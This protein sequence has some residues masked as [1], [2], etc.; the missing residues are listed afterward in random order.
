[1][2]YEPAQ[3][4]ERLFTS[5][6]DESRDS[7][8][9][10]SQWNGRPQGCRGGHKEECAHRDVILNNREETVHR[11]TGRLSTG[12]LQKVVTMETENI[13]QNQRCTGKI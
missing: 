13:R 9:V 7:T 6:G 8:G 12:Q 11:M 5:R 10:C 3:S 1:M 2:L 4:L